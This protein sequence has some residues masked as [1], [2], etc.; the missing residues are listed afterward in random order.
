EEVNLIV[1]VAPA[2]HADEHGAVGCLG[3]ELSV[4]RLFK[5]RNLLAASPRLV[6]PVELHGIAKPRGNEHSLAIGRPAAK[7]GGPHVLVLPQTLRKVRGNE[8]HILRGDV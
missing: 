5:K 7:S 4:S 1:L 3:N 6:D 2:A 8:W